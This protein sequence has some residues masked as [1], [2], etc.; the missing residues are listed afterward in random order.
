MN[1]FIEQKVANFLLEQN[2]SEEI[3][4]ELEDFAIEMVLSGA[5]DSSVAQDAWKMY[6][7]KNKVTQ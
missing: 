1:N 4:S 5:M 3:R 7:N 6:N 2:L